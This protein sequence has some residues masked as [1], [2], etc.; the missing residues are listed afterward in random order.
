MYESYF[1]CYGS[2]NVY[3]DTFDI[4]SVSDDDMK[5]INKMN[6]SNKSKLL[7][8]EIE[9]FS[10]D[11]DSYSVW[12]CRFKNGEELVNEDFDIDDVKEVKFDEEAYEFDCSKAFA[13][14]SKDEGIKKYEPVAKEG[15]E[16]IEES[17]LSNFVIENET[18]KC[19]KGSAGIV[20]IPQGIKTIG[21][22]AFDGNKMLVKLVIPESVEYIDDCAFMGCKS[23]SNIDMLNPNAKFGEEIF[24]GCKKFYQRKYVTAGTALIEYR[25]K[26]AEVVIPSSI[27]V[28]CDYAFRGNSNIQKVVLI[29]G[30]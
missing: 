14:G 3:L 15:D 24:C 5:I 19:Y 30:E 6:L 13:L 29:Q 20:S 2:C 27:N 1:K 16:L 26:D 11:D 4:N 22:H 7:E 8:C 17:D 18:L 9:A 10:F 23:L 21:C 28:I 12:H 25:G